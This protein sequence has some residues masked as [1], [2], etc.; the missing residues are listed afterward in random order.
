MK[1]IVLIVL[2]LFGVNIG[3]SYG[4]VLIG[5]P[6]VPA[7]GAI[8][9]LKERNADADNA[10]ANKGFLMPRVK[11]TSVTSLAPI[12]SATMATDAT[13]KKSHIGLQVYHVGGSSIDAGLKIWSG[14]KW[15]ELF[16]TPKGQWIYMPPFPIKMFEATEQTVVLYDEYK[17]QLDTAKS[18]VPLWA[19]NEVTFVITGY[20]ALAFTKVE[21]KTVGGR[22]V[23]V[24]T[25]AL[26]K[27]TAA[28]YLNIIIVK[29]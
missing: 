13:V 27:L 2:M 7:A 10:T 22:Q 4:Q 5:T 1:K 11:L 3:L 15:E 20:D 16:S 25:A 28:S 24:Y 17:K 8:L 9:D 12:V 29:K 18:G 26:G 14:E 6:G 21:I 19:E 23:L